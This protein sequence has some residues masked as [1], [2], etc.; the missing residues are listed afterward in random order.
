MATGILATS[1]LAAGV[2]SE[3][4]T[5]TE[6]YAQ[7]PSSGCPSV[8]QFGHGHFAQIGAMAGCQVSTSSQDSE[9]IFRGGAVSQAGAGCLKSSGIRVV[10]DLRSEGEKGSEKAWVENT[11]GT[12]YSF[13]MAT[14]SSVPSKSCKNAG[15][16][17][18]Q[19][20]RK[21]AL[22]AVDLMDKILSSDSNVQIFVHCARGEDRTG[23]VIG[24]YRAL[25]E[26]CPKA[27]ARSEMAAFYYT[28]YAPL[29]SV[30]DQET[31]NLP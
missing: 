29:K 4:A 10:I 24:L 12:Y 8:S 21:N 18:S 26:R 1:L 16:S 31:A 14:D 17:A 30:W 28:A 20:N 2:S 27:K 13:P 25:K 11:S 5:K 23:L 3:A 15:L 19:C 22:G 7:L 6:S 9:R